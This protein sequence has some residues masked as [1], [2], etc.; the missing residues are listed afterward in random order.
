M[1]GNHRAAKRL[2]ELEA[3]RPFSSNTV[4]DEEPMDANEEMEEE[5]EDNEED[6]EGKTRKLVRGILRTSAD[7]FAMSASAAVCRQGATM[8]AMGSGSFDLDDQPTQVQE[9]ETVPAHKGGNQSSSNRG[10]KLKRCSE[11]ARLANRSPSPSRRAAEDVYKLSTRGGATTV[12]DVSRVSSHRAS[13]NLYDFTGFQRKDHTQEDRKGFRKVHCCGDSKA[14]D[15]AEIVNDRLQ[16]CAAVR[17]PRVPGDDLRRGRTGEE[18]AAP[19]SD[20]FCKKGLLMKVPDYLTK[21]A[22]AS[23][24]GERAVPHLRPPDCVFDT[25]KKNT[26]KNKAG[27]VASVTVPISAK[28]W[29]LQAIGLKDDEIREMFAQMESNPQLAAEHVREVKSEWE[30]MEARVNRVP[31]QADFLV[32]DRALLEKVRE[33]I[34]RFIECTN[35][36]KFQSAEPLKNADENTVKLQSKASSPDDLSNKA[37]NLHP[38]SNAASRLQPETPCPMPSCENSGQVKDAVP[39]DEKQTLPSFIPMEDYV[40]NKYVVQPE[41]LGKPECKF[42][43]SP[44]DKRWYTVVFPALQPGKREDVQLLGEWLQHAMRKNRCEKVDGRFENVEAAF[45]LHSIAFLEIVRQVD[46]HCEERGNLL[47]HV[48]RQLLRIFNQVLVRAEPKLK[49]TEE[50][51]KRLRNELEMTKDQLFRMIYSLH[52]FFNSHSNGR[53]A[54]ETGGRTSETRGVEEARGRT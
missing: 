4:D 51:T 24:G 33:L 28:Q 45:V 26:K 54:Q 44:Y 6:K 31:P 43:Y 25:K 27:T 47:L 22:G 32:K 12:T 38:E 36:E 23:R 15:I 52:R 21:L 48:W 39:P 30:A 41:L 18:E 8:I 49:A 14:A 46:I 10:P 29:L 53:G 17:T 5:I 35:P 13:P 34:V 9:A 1:V 16:A 37:E 11:E 7:A 42:A 2:K 40:V 3:M 50:E 20:T 19:I